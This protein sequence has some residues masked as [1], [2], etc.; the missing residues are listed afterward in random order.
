MPSRPPRPAA[1]TGSY[2]TIGLATAGFAL[3]E[4]LIAPQLARLTDQF[5]QTRVLPFSLLAHGLAVAG[6][7]S[8][9]LAVAALSV[10]TRQALRAR[11]VEAIGIRE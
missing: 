9:L 2:G 5:G 7:V 4:A 6:S 8:A 3:A 11:L 10:A 1:S